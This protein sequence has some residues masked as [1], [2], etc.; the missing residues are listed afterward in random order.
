MTMIG[1]RELR[2]QTTE[3]LRRIREEG[4]EYIITYQGQPV[5]VLLPLDAEAVEQAILDVG[6]Q[7]TPH[8]WDA[9][10]QV[11]AAV[12]ERWPESASTQAVLDDIRR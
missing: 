9:Y 8:G 2:Q 10:A 3:V 11:A 6:K 4:A 7:G 12:R 1:V 5:A